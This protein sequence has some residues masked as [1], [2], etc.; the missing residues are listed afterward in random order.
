MSM[1]ERLKGARGFRVDVGLVTGQML[2]GMIKQV[3]ESNN[4][5]SDCATILLQPAPNDTPFA[6]AVPHIMY[7]RVVDEANTIQPP[8]TIQGRM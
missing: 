5:L 1:V 3:E 8:R 2:R 4:D 6:I 7:A